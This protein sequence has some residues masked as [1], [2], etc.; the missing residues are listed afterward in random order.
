MFPRFSPRQ[1]VFARVFCPVF[2]LHGG[3]YIGR[4]WT[5]AVQAKIIFP[6]FSGVREVIAGE[7]AGP[8]GGAS[9]TA[10]RLSEAGWSAAPEG[11]N[12]Y[13]ETNEKN[14]AP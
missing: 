7:A 12:V 4:A 2:R 14:Q 3:K 5:K 10:I 6:V 11:R 1:G 13:S 8:N 9:V